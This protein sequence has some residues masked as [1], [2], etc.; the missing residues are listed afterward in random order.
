MASQL[1]GERMKLERRLTNACDKN[2][3]REEARTRITN[4]LNHVCSH[5]LPD[6]V[7]ADAL[8][9]KYQRSYTRGS[10]A[11]YVL[12]A[13]SVVVAAAQA[14]FLPHVHF[15]V[16]A[17]ILLIVFVIGVIKFGNYR[18]WHRRWQD[19]RL[20]AE[21]LRHAVF[22][23]MMDQPVASP[24]AQSLYDGKENADHPADKAFLEIGR[25]WERQSQK[26]LPS[27][28]HLPVIKDFLLTAWLENQRDWHNRNTKIHKRKHARLS[29][30][31]EILFYLT[32]GAAVLH[33]SHAGG[34]IWGK[35][36]TFLSISCPA[37]GAAFGAM[38]NHFE[39]NKL[40]RRSEQMVIRLNDIIERIRKAGDIDHVR[41]IAEEAERLMMGET[42]DWYALISSRI[43][44]KP[45]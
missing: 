18:R 32:L 26:F 22:L 15:P 12:A 28:D 9:L 38:R 34:E 31:G 27:N 42:V 36:W 23:A 33:F 16:L 1:S 4:R 29:H 11:I 7:K 44:D 2:G 35:V 19:S 14:L 8:A 5:F 43:L 21:R 41:R 17:E 25:N 6:F 39:H 37:L 45:A 40:F 20:L 24:I 10:T 3:L 30:C 13:L